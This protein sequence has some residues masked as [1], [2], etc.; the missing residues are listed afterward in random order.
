MTQDVIYVVQ[1]QIGLVGAIYELGDA[2][3]RAIGWPSI[4]LVGYASHGRASA[5]LVG[6]AYAPPH[7][8][9]SVA[10]E[11]RFEDIFLTSKP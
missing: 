7:E 11:V 8:K 3:L 1:L 2:S 6:R 9:M 10:Y 4:L 5:L